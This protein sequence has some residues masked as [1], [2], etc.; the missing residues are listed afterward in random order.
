[1]L[2]R[3]FIA[4]LGSPAVKGLTSWSLFVMFNCVFVTLPCGILGQVWYFIVSIPDLCRLSY[5]HMLP[6]FLLCHPRLFYSATSLFIM[7]SM[8]LLC[9]QLQ[10]IS[11]FPCC[12]HFQHV[13]SAFIVLL[14]FPTYFTN[15]FI[16]S[17]LN[18]LNLLS[19]FYQFQYTY[20][21]FI[22]YRRLHYVK[23]PYNMSTTSYGRYVFIMLPILLRP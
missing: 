16:L 3:H 2:S 15:V 17:Q 13:Y 6:T 22:I 18:M 21:F 1:M 19:L 8:C 10:I 4:A 23:N 9:Q 12:C 20:K 7:S 14:L 5:F 11:S